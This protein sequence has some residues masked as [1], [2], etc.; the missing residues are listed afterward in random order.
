MGRSEFVW[1]VRW[2]IW[3]VQ[4]LL[5]GVQ[6]VIRGVRRLLWGAFGAPVWG[7]RPLPM[8]E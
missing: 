1:G 7:V 4:R 5:W 6:D 3:G 8:G 2:M